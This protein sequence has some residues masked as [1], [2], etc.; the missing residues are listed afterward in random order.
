MA[1]DEILNTLNREIA[2]GRSIDDI[3]KDIFIR[4][5]P[6]FTNNVSLRK[7]LSNSSI[8]SA[9][10]FI[11]KYSGDI[12]FSKGLREILD[13][14]SLAFKKNQNEVTHIILDTYQDFVE[15]EN[16]MWSIRQRTVPVTEDLYDKVMFY[17]EYIGNTLEI[18]VKGI[19]HEIYALIRLINGKNIDYNKICKTDFG[20]AINN[21]LTHNCFEEILQVGPNNMKLSDWRNIA[22]HNSYKITNE[23]ITCTYGKIGTSFTL[24]VDEFLDCI[25]KIIR[26]GNI[27]NIARCIFVYD[28]LD[29]LSSSGAITKSE[30]RESMIYNQ[31]KMTLIVQ[32]FL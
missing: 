21:I 11:I 32:G 28:N 8:V 4:L 5:S 12:M 23:E 24:Q 15:R 17:F 2:N 20:V 13:C 30:F 1:V 26:N 16:M 25:Y 19:I 7:N 6:Y 9:Y 29:A 27:L 3:E 22:N 10:E 14:Y 31:I 18:S